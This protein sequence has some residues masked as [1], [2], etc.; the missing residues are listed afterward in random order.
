VLVYCVVFAMR[1]NIVWCVSP[2]MPSEG[3]AEGQWAGRGGESSDM[4]NVGI[5]SDHGRLDALLGPPQEESSP[6]SPL[7]SFSSRK[8]PVH[9]RL[10][11]LE[12]DEDGACGISTIST[13]TT[14]LHAL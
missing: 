6:G 7:S 10:P 13:H 4:M 8:S 1:S 3:K 5:S 11:T 14:L 2:R 9:T 12:G